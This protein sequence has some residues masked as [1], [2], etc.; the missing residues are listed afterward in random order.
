MA[1]GQR[2][3]RSARRAMQHQV[4]RRIVSERGADDPCRDARAG[5]RAPLAFGRR[6]RS[7]PQRVRI[8]DQPTALA[9]WVRRCAPPDRAVPDGAGCE[10]AL[11]AHR[12]RSTVS[13]GMPRRRCPAR[14]GSPDDGGRRCGDLS[15]R[16]SCPRARTFRCGSAR[17]SLR[18]RATRRTSEGR[19]AQVRKAVQPRRIWAPIDAVGGTRAPRARPPR[20][21]HRHQLQRMTRDR[22]QERTWIHRRAKLFARL[23]TGNDPPHHRPT[24]PSTRRCSRPSCQRSPRPEST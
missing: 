18:R 16:R 5:L 7:A 20:L 8:A 22:S 19:N 4:G 13:K 17:N 2:F 14:R 15:T 6:S 23:G 9:R 11:H 10:H 21:L 3:E 12:R 24:A 1:A